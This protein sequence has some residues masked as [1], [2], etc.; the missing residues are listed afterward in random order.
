VLLA[1]LTYYVADE[2]VQFVKQQRK[3]LVTALHQRWGYAPE[4]TVKATARQVIGNQDGGKA[5]TEGK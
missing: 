5:A 3:D 2:H 1:S 4:M